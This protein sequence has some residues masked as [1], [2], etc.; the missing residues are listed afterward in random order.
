MTWGRSMPTRRSPDLP[1]I[2]ILTLIAAGLVLGNV[3]L[4]LVRAVLTGLLAFLFPGYALTAWL[5]ARQPIT[6]AARMVFSLGVSIALT[7]AIGLILHVAGPGL[8]AQNWAIFLSTITLVGCIAGI[9]KRPQN[10]IAE[11]MI[12]NLT[13]G[14]IVVIG[15]AIG[16]ALVAV[17]LAQDGVRQQP[18]PGFTQLWMLPDEN[19]DSGVQ[20][21]IRNEEGLPVAYELRL[22]L[23]G[24]VVEAWDVIPLAPGET[25][26]MTALIPEGAG[27]NEV[28]TAL[29]YRVDIDE[30]VYRS[31]T[32][33][34]DR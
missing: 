14:Q 10:V 34:L 15:A 23:G 13:P 18:R 7:A 6:V 28:V 21:G 29:L 26:E 25:W 17:R 24:E 8:T 4:R 1:L 22:E 5:F 31:A 3:E 19:D 2:M 16:L 12:A 32:L 11:R 30:A 20:L 27:G 33:T 9:L